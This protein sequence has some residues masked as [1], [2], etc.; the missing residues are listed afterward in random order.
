MLLNYTVHMLLVDS[1]P[2]YFLQTLI[3]FL[4]RQ[5]KIQHWYYLSSLSLSDFS[6]HPI[7]FREWWRVIQREIIP[8]DKMIILCGLVP[9]A[10]FLLKQRRSFK[11]WECGLGHATKW[12]GYIWWRGNWVNFR[13]FLASFVCALVLSTPKDFITEYKSQ[14]YTNERDGDL[15]YVPLGVN[16][17]LFVDL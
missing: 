3:T 17:S 9:A 11:Y 8:V 6:R 15:V 1:H 16:M 5:L 2:N 14:K 7:S 4:L 13:A 10:K 12:S